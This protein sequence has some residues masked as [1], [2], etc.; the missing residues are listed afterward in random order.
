MKEFEL[1]SKYFKP[2]AKGFSGALSLEDDIAIIPKDK[3][4]DYIITS[5][6]MAEGVHFPENSMAEIIASRLL[7]SNLSDIASSG[8]IP[9]YY[10]ITGSI[11][12]GLDEKWFK[13]FSSKLAELN[14]EYNIHLLGGDTIKT[15]EQ[16]FF[17]ITMIGEVEA[18]KA[19]LRST[20]LEGDDIYVSGNIGDAYIGLQILKGEIEKF[21]Y[22]DK[23]YFINRYLYPTARIELARNL[24][25]IATACTDISDGLIRDLE[26][27]CIASKVN[28]E[29]NKEDIPVAIKDELFFEQISGGDDYELIFT[30]RQKDRNKIKN[31]A[32]K[33]N[34][35][36]SKIGKIT[37]E[38][39]GKES[40]KV[41]ISHKGKPIKYTQKGFEHEV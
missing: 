8:G 36:I 6:G 41:K 29:I 15:N 1:I 38:K 40:D 11:K 12:K 27:I 7:V 9:K 32:K 19:L 34:I 37:K 21:S 33:L 18:G 24:I 10:S 25:G 14:K 17:S 5:D 35:K 16:L 28:A 13:G 31:L 2:L 22:Q 23:N 39:L 20:A 30:A 4:F 3:N 26:N